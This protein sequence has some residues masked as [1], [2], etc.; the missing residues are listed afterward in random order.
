MPLVVVLATQV[1]SQ[2]IVRHL[3]ELEFELS[4]KMLAPLSI[5]QQENLQFDSILFLHSELVPQ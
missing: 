1:A 3:V 2:I 4:L 5:F